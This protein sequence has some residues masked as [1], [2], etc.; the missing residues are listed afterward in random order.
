MQRTPD[1]WG[2]PG[3]AFA[4]AFVLL[5]VR[6][7]PH[8]QLRLHA[9]VRKALV[10]EQDGA[11]VAAMANDAPERLVDRANRGL[12]VPVT[13]ASPAGRKTAKHR[14]AR[15]TARRKGELRPPRSGCVGLSHPETRA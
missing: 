4:K 15:T 10:G 6:S 13:R 2:A 12:R 3:E 11:I 7:Y 9:A 8:G 5:H 14:H 1:A